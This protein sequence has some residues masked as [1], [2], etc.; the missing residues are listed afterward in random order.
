MKDL[1]ILILFFFTHL[2]SAQKYNSQNGNVIFEASVPLFE[3][4]FA[5]DNKNIVILNADTGDLAS[6]SL[7]RNFRFKTNLMEEHFNESYAETSKYPKATF[8]GKI[9]N[10]DKTKLTASPQKYNI[11]GN[12]NFHSVDRLISSSSTIYL[13]DGKIYLKGTFITKPSDFKVTVPKMVMKKISENVKV[14]YQ[15]ILSKR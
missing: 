1:T 8:T 10:F 14:E 12:L 9:I 7:V 6:V 3:D 13:K 2:V 15:Y 11:Q 4:I 5:Q